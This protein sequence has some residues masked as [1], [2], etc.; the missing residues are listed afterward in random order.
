MHRCAAKCCDDSSLSIE[1]VQSC[2]KN[3]QSDL[4]S[5]TG[6][7]QREI[8]AFEA[9]LERCAMDCQDKVRERVTP[10]TKPEDMDKF[11][12]VRNDCLIQGLKGVANGG[13]LG[14]VYEDCA[15]QC[16]DTNIHSLTGLSQRI[17]SNIKAKSYA[18]NFL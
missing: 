3:C 9:K 16:I 13:K 14:Q 7:V 18:T 15:F 4:T 12:K 8:T 5:A 10:D 11:R 6:Y 17:K 1:S 2:V